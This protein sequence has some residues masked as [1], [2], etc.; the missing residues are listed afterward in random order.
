MIQ[1]N[2]N[3]LCNIMNIT[4]EDVM[5]IYSALTPNV[6]YYSFI[7]KASIG[8]RSSAR[9]DRCITNFVLNHQASVYESFKSDQITY[10]PSVL[11]FSKAGED[12]IRYINNK[13]IKSSTSKGLSII[14]QKSIEYADQ[15]YME[16]LTAK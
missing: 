7:Q 6:N 13:S 16:L 10:N 14:Q 3:I 4:E 8:M 12:L 2:R 11:A 15:V 1:I 5:R 9:I